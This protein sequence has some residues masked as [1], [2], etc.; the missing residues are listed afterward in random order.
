MPD[1]TLTKKKKFPFGRFLAWKTSDISAAG[2]NIIVTGYLTLY[3]TNFLGL[4]GT[5]VGLILLISNIIDAVTDLIAGFVIDNTHSKL[6]KGRPYEI[7]IIGMWICT[8]LMFSGPTAASTGV[9]FAWVFFMYTFIFGVFNTLRGAGSTAYMIRAFD[10]DRDLVG[11]VGS[12]GGIVTTLGSMAVSLTFPMMM[13]RIATSAAGW[14]SLI[15]LYSVPLCVIGIGRFVFVKENPAI[16]AGAQH[17][18]VTLQDVWAV[19][20]KNKYVWFYAGIQILFN[21]VLNM[22]AQT[23]YFTYIVGNTDILGIVSIMGIML[24]PAMLFMPVVLKKLSV[25]RVVFFGAIFAIVGYA[26]NFVAGGK[27]PLL[28]VAAMLMACLQLPLSYLCAVLLM[29]LF[30]YNEYKGLAR[31]EGTTNQIA[32]GIATQIGQ[33]LGGFLLGVLLDLGGFITSENGAFVAQPDSALMMIRL[34]YSVIPIILIVGILVCVKFLGKL[35]EEMPEIEKVLAERH[36]ALGVESA[37]EAAD[38]P[39]K[40]LTETDIADSIDKIEAERHQGEE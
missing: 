21:T 2:L 19:F 31:L 20:T 11:K 10:N 33:G 3:C 8:A 23:Y 12:Y 9:K 25:S 24:L 34:M 1:T 32:H 18:K 28:I 38:Y 26:I 39:G 37:E 4:S 5:T 6:G 27:V 36:A 17:N 35:D 14:R 30:N 40:Y 16:D 29:D 7:G 22:S 15:L 13:G